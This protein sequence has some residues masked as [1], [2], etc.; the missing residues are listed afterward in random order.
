MPNTNGLDDMSVVCKRCGLIDD[1]RTQK[2][3]PHT[4]AIC[5][6]CDRHIKFL[7]KRLTNPVKVGSNSMGQIISIRIDV[8]KIDKARL[9]VGKQ[10]TYL[11]ITALMKDEADSY[12]NHGMVVQQV[13]QEERKNGVKGPILGNAKILGGGGGNPEASPTGGAVNAA[14]PVAAPSNLPF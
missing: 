5:N 10:G 3:G 4:E 9:F 11:D 2:N 8:T 12:G 1:Y 6:G 14:A 7:P 13:S